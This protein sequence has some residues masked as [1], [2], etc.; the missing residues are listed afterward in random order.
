MRLVGYLNKKLISDVRTNLAVVVCNRLQAEGVLYIFPT[1]D[2]HLMVTTCPV[3]ISGLSQQ[4][5]LVML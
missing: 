2:D 4:M 1:E 5:H 3:C